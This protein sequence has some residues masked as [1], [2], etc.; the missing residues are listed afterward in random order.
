MSPDGLH[1]AYL[2][3]PGYA[4][5]LDVLDSRSGI[6]TEIR[7][8]GQRIDPLFVTSGL[9]GTGE[10][11]IC[12]NCYGGINPTGKVFAYDVSTGS[13]QEVNVPVLLS[14]LAGASLSSGG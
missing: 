3:N 4:F 1:I 10:L 7:T 8:S 13:E 6:A 5:K 11:Q 12:D 2:T 14:P 9:M